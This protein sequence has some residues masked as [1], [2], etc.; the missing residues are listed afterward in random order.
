MGTATRK[1]HSPEQKVQIVMEL[2][3]EENSPRQSTKRSHPG[4]DDDYRFIFSS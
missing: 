4:L 3:K 1:H 2:L